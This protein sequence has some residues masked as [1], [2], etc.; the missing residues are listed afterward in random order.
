MTCKCINQAHNC[1]FSEGCRVDEKISKFRSSELRP[2]EDIVAPYKAEIA[3]LTAKLEAAEYFEKV[4]SDALKVMRQ[5]LAEAQRDAV[6]TSKLL[7][8]I[9]FEVKEYAPG[10]TDLWGRVA[11]VVWSDAAVARSAE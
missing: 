4:S 10:F 3:T 9:E 2:I 7:Q 11:L 5:Q 1:D 6:A 8:E